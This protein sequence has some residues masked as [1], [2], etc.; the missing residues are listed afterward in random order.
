MTEDALDKELESYWIKKGEKGTVANHLDSEMDEYWKGAGKNLSKHGS[1]ANEI[2]KVSM[3]GDN[4]SSM[5]NMAVVSQK[6][7]IGASPHY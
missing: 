3:S 4:S 6:D 2:T 1:N 5:I 7:F